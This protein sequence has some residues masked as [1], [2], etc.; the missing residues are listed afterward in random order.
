MKATSG[1]ENGFTA[2]RITAAFLVLL[3]HSYVT[4]GLGADW[5]GR[6]THLSEFSGL[7]VDAFFSL[8]GF[9]ICGALLRDG[10]LLRYVQH[11]TLRILPALVALS[12]VTVFVVGPLVTTD[13]LYLQR[14]QT[15]GY[16]MGGTVY[17]ARYLLPG[18]F[19]SLPVTVV[20]GSLW[21]LPLEVT[22]Y[23]VLLGLSWCGA[24]NWRGLATVM[25]GCL[26]LHLNDVFPRGETLY[27]MEVLHL[28][29]LGTLFLG[30]ALLAT[31]QDK[32][33][34]SGWLA[35]AAAAVIAVA[36]WLDLPDWHGWARAYLLL[37]P[38]VVI[39]TG[40]SVYPR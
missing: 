5:L 36:G 33:K 38:Y 24:L 1:K 17:G 23:V 31:L 9:L 34:F 22:C 39:A 3:T 35:L 37:F 13:S 7:G 11:R 4:L 2:I 18:V 32:L 6:T 15:Y 19:T 28:D 29:R 25:F 27:G 20:N 40:L 21:T 14:S 8:S 12:L 10:S 30:G 26:A 16:L